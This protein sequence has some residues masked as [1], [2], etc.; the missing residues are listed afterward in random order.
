MVHDV[1]PAA[2]GTD[3]HAA[4]DDLAQRGQVGSDAEQR[5]G[6]TQ[7]HAKAGHDFVEDQQGSA[8][9]RQLAQRPQKRFA[10][11][12]TAHVAHHRLHDH[13][14]DVLAF[15]LERFAKHFDIV[16]RQHQ[17]VLGRAPGHAG[18]VGHAQRRGGTAGGHQ[19][20][21]D[22]PVVVAGELDDPIAPG[23]AARQPDGAH[24]GFG[25]RVDQPH[26]FDRGNQVDDQFGQLVFRFGRRT[27]TGS[28]VNRR[29]HRLSHARMTMSQDHRAPR[30]D[31]VDVAIAVDVE[32]IG[33]FAPLEDDRLATHRPERSRRTVHAARHQLLGSCKDLVTLG[34]FHRR[35]AFCRA[36][37]IGHCVDSP[38]SESGTGG[39]NRDGETSAKLPGNRVHLR[40]GLTQGEG[41]RSGT[42]AADRKTRG[43]PEP[44]AIVT[45]ACMEACSR[46]PRIPAWERRGTIAADTPP[47]AAMAV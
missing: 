25:A 28:R 9:V 10:R 45:A 27:E 18:R 8:V 40:C 29:D 47:S 11:D 31:V 19:Q 26:L 15:S 39:A 34:M 1:G 36:R 43:L 4:A 23:E 41:T 12:H 42:R 7:G 46:S 32:Q 22:V 35:I 13:G 14:G 37:G 17:R 30:S 38:A 5:L 20:A 33:T 44:G 2:V 16:V 3:R 6:T 21:V 24:R